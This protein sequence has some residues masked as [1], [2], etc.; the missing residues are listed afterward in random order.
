MDGHRSLCLVISPY[1]KRHQ[2]V[3]TFFNQSGLLHTMEQIMGLPPM[4]Q[5]DA[6]GPLMFDCFTNPPD[7]TPYTA[8]PN[9]INL[10]SGGVALLSPKARYYARKVQKMDFSKPDLV[11][12]DIFNR[13]LW[14]SIKGDARYPSEFVGGHGKGLKQLG[15]VLTQAGKD[16][17]D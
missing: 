9:N 1:T 4:N 11:N 12:D 10:A 17:D 15:L 16:P 7:F 14:H 13:Y 2:V 6:M 5:Q 8:L 3:S